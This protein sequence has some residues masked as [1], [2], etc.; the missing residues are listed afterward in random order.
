MI[1]WNS[2]RNRQYF[3]RM[4]EK[5]E[6]IYIWEA[7]VQRGTSLWPLCRIWVE[8]IKTIF[9]LQGF[10]DFLESVF[11]LFWKIG[12]ILKL[13]AFSMD[14]NIG[15]K[16]CASFTHL[17]NLASNP[18]IPCGRVHISLMI[19]SLRIKMLV[20]QCFIALTFMHKSETRV[21]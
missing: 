12:F 19:D 5:D 6:E 17:Y 7:Q 13:Y 11:I 9:I 2:P 14:H 4:D 8:Y 20:E 10:H 18:L 1:W 15:G 16:R 21:V 3:L